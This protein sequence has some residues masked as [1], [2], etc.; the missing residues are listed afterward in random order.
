MDPDGRFSQTIPI[1]EFVM[2]LEQLGQ[3]FK[4]ATPQLAIVG[5][6]VLGVVL[7]AEGINYAQN[8]SLEN[9]LGKIDSASV[10]AGAPASLP[11]DDPKSKGTQTSSKTLY[12]KKGIHIDV[13]NP[14][15][16]P[17]QIHVQ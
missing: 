6:V 16:R 10:S 5:C 4:N 13:E 8:K 12:N 14:G 15:H 1:P 17:G 3:E 9:A 2:N 11:L 7:I